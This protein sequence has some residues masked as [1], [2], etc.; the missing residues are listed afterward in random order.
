[1]EQGYGGVSEFSY[2]GCLMHQSV[3]QETELGRRLAEAGRAFHRLKPNVFKAKGV[4]QTTRLRIYQACVLSILNS[5][6]TGRQRRGR[7][8]TRS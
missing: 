2:L 3:Q 5:S 6:C 1:M 7:S 4:S 8:P